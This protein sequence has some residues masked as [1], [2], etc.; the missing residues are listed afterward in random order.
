MS[1]TCASSHTASPHTCPQPQPTFLASHIQ[2]PRQRLYGNNRPRPGCSRFETLA[3]ERMAGMDGMDV[4]ASNID[5]WHAQQSSCA[6]Q[7]DLGLL[8]LSDLTA[9]A[10]TPREIPAAPPMGRILSH[11]HHISLS[12]NYKVSFFRQIRENP[13]Y[14]HRGNQQGGHSG[15]R[16]SRHPV[17]HT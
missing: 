7:L 4:R 15:Q 10:N 14:H 11:L 8:H 5:S 1:A 13:L 17:L 9:P 2:L 12:I 3:P 6:C 16:I